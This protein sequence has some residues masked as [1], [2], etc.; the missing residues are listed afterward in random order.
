MEKMTRDQMLSEFGTPGVQL[1]P[2]QVSPTVQAL[3][4]SQ[5]VPSLALGFVHRPVD[6]S[7]VPATWH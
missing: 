1:P 6:V 4:S 3:P 5:E 7:Q 2:L